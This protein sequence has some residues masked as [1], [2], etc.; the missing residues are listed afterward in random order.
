MGHWAKV[1]NY[2][3]NIGTVTNIVHVTVD[4]D[5]AAGLLNGDGSSPSDWI[6][7]SHNVRGGVHYVGDGTGATTLSIPSPNQAETIAAQDGRQPVSY[8]H[9]TLPTTMLV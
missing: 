3:D 8:T 5:V 2:V 7:Y 1:E 9:L 4:A 6:Q